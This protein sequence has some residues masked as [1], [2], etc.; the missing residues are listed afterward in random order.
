MPRVPALRPAPRPTP[1]VPPP[2]ATCSVTDTWLT[3]RWGLVRSVP[4]LGDGFGRGLSGTTP[5]LVGASPTTSPPRWRCGSPLIAAGSRLAMG[6]VAAAGIA[7]EAS[8]SALVRRDRVLMLNRLPLRLRRG[9]RRGGECSSD[10]VAT[11]AAEEARLRRDAGALCVTE[12]P[13]PMRCNS[14]LGSWLPVFS[15]RL[16][17]SLVL[18]ILLTTDECSA[19]KRR[20]LSASWA[21]AC[22]WYTMCVTYKVERNRR[23]PF[24]TY[25]FSR[26]V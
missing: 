3:L 11:E 19:R 20:R 22:G 2:A 25:L 4:R 8:E 12:E 18:I 7:W 23:A 10:P 26:Q 15:S 13:A 1:A 14:A 9:W 21:C 16:S 5:L 24:I 17:P 6:L